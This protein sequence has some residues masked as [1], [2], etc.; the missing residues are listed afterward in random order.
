MKKKIIIA[1]AGHG[2]LAAAAILGEKGYDITVFEKNKRKDM[3]YDWTDVFQISCFDDAGLPR[4][5]ANKY[6][7]S[8]NITYTNP[9][10]TVHITMPDIQVS[11]NSIMDRKDLCRYLIRLCEKNGVKFRFGTEIIAPVADKNRV[12]GM[13]VRKNDKLSAEF[14]DLIIDAAGMDSP[15]RT[16]LPER[17][18]IQNEIRG[19]EVFTVYRAFFS[20]TVASSPEHKYIVHFFHMRKPGI[21]WLITEKNYMDI[22]IGRFGEELTEDDISEALADLRATYP[23]VGDEIIRGGQVARIPLRRTLPIIVADGYAAIGDSAGMTI[24]IIG[25]GIANSIRAGK[26]LAEAVIDDTDEEYTAKTLWKYQY[27]YFTNVGNKYVVIDKIKR[28]AS[29]LSANDVD[30]L[31]EKEIL[32][33]GELSIGEEQATAMPLSTLSRKF[34]RAIPKLPFVANTARTFAKFGAV[35][36]ILKKMPEEYDKDAVAQWAEQYKNV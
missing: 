14:G 24:P 13:V 2:G 18:G 30:Y 11:S 19:S 31:L 6:H 32:S 35:K 22:L 10:K 26:Y 7:P 8:Y 23:A 27:N 9:G 12:I 17:F 29:S 5:P 16:L 3:G 25:S 34:I 28:L 4:P 36:K 15:L 1:G 33:A 21:S 20:K